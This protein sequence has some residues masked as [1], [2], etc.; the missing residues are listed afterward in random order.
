MTKPKKLQKRA[1]TRHNSDQQQLQTLFNPIMLANVLPVLR[2]YNVEQP[3]VYPPPDA[4]VEH[5]EELGP[6]VWLRA[7]KTGKEGGLQFG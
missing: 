4:L 6:N 7:T 3:V 1:L 5:F 2:A